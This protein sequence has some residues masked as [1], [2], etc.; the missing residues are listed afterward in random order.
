MANDKRRREL[1]RAKAQR[2]AQRR[3]QATARARRNK[4]IGLIAAGIVGAVFVAVAVWPEGESTPAAS[5]ANSEQPSASAEPATPGPVATPAGVSCKP[6]AA[7]RA[8]DRKWPKPDNMSVSGTPDWVLDTNCGPIT[9]R[10]AAN[11][12]PETVNGLSFLSDQGYY[13]DTSCHRLTTA[14]I[15]VLQCG[16][17]DGSGA[18]SPG[19]ELPDENLPPAKADNYPAGT[20]AMAN[21][22]PGTAGS[23]FFIVYQ[24]STLG[25]K[26]NPPSHSIVGKVID[27]LDVVEYVAAAGVEAGSLN[28]VDGPPAQPLQITSA[29]TNQGS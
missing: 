9:I 7:A 2:Q 26:A 22:G 28:A 4:R 23:Q 16:S 19:F 1:A 21:S 14:G 5:P 27:G 8:E 15:Y 6:P 3:E 24:D 20:V 17:V 13:N 12:A 25:D 18:D 29:R 11:K 10:L